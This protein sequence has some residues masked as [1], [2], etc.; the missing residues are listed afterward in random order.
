MNDS[1]PACPKYKTTLAGFFHFFNFPDSIAVASSCFR[2][3]RAG[4][5][6]GPAS[7]W[8]LRALHEN[9]YTDSMKT[10]V[11]TYYL[12]MTDPAQHRR[13]RAA[14]ELEVRRAEIICPELNRFLYTA[15]GG[16]WFWTQ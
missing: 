12:E 1:T 9:K 3:A 15:V 14:L 8:R 11:I 10:T 4:G 13:A 7:S 2:L 16:N 5:A 6:R